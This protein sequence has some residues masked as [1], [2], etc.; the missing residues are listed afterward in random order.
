MYINFNS[1]NNYP[2]IQLDDVNPK[3][4]QLSR[5]LMSTCRGVGRI[6]IHF[7]L[8]DVNPTQAPIASVSGTLQITG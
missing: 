3:K 1:F 7:R 5:Q 2:T 6:T 8:D 4:E